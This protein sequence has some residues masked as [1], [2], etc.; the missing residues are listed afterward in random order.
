MAWNEEDGSG[1]FKLVDFGG[2]LDGMVWDFEKV[3]WRWVCE[4]GFWW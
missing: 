2:G 4:K 3:F 1:E